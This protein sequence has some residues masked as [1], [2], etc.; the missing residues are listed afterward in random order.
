MDSR[1]TLLESGYLLLYVSA[2]WIAGVFLAD[3]AWRTHLLGCGRPVLYVLVVAA[4]LVLFLSY[5]VKMSGRGN[6]AFWILLLGIGMLGFARYVSHPL[7]PC[8]TASY[9]EFYADGSNLTVRGIISG[10]PEERENGFRYVM[11][12]SEIGFQNG[13][14]LSVHGKVLFSMGLDSPRLYYGDEVEVLGKLTRPRSFEDFDYR[15]FLARKGIYSLVLRPRFRLLSRGHGSAFWRWVYSLRRSSRR[16]IDRLLPEP[17]ASLMDGILLGIESTIPRDLYDEFNK[18]GTSHIIVISGFNITIVAGLLMLLFGRLLGDRWGALSA[19]AGIALYTV[20]VGANPPVVRAAF[21]GGIYVLGVSLGRQ[22]TAIVSLFFSAL[23]MTLID[24]LVLWDLGFQ[25][26]FAATLSLV[27]F[28]NPIEEWVEERLKGLMPPSIAEKTLSFLN[29]A[30]IVTFSAQIL[31]VPL[32]AHSFHRV[33][34]VSLP[35]NFFILPVQPYVMIGG[36]V[37]LAGAVLSHAIAQILAAIPWLFLHYTVWFVRFFAG[38]PFASATV[39]RFGTGW[40]VGYYA[41]VGAL[42]LRPGKVRG[43]VRN[44]FR[45]FR[46][47]HVL[48]ALVLLDVILWQAGSHSVDGKLHVFFL[49]VGDGD[50]VLVQTPD[51]KRVL[52][53]GGGS[54]TALLNAVGGCLPFWDHRIDVLVVSGI[55]SRFSRGLGAFLERYSVGEVF[56]SENLRDSPEWKKLETES[57]RGDSS[58]VKPLYPGARLLLGKGAVVDV[59]GRGGRVYALR[60]AW[61]ETCFLLPADTSP[62]DESWMAER[63]GGGLRCSVL[64]APEGGKKGSS[65]KEFVQAVHPEYVVFSFGKRGKRYG[66]P[67]ADVL[68]RYEKA[69][70]RALYT[71]KDGSI[72]L[73]SDGR[74][75]SLSRPAGSR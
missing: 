41:L 24:P 64:L 58:K 36:A 43:V 25:L 13:K 16:K 19:L 31:T 10:Y 69:G 23:L 39:P 29:D 26:S 2:S 54:G 3:K 15:A 62:A 4:F 75:V 53:N 68:W 70:A 42:A 18:T 74:S 20:F 34:L 57:L 59:V 65:P 17:E 66:Y 47:E 28:S 67:N 61:G 7:F 73:I 22:S 46:V 14:R 49:D 8:P 1:G 60:I 11:Q 51:G 9:V 52:V 27:L 48:V 30:L 5:F 55:G 56:V 32:I 71:C 12:V 38:L 44:A 37:M 33:S 35:A 72:E 6:F 21:M 50:A 63:W 40:L 45:G